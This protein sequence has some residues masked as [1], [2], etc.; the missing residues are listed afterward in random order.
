M[1]LK[2]VLTRAVKILFATAL[3]GLAV[4]FVRESLV[5]VWLRLILS[6]VTGAIVYFI[7]LYFL[8]LLRYTGLKRIG[9]SFGS[10]FNK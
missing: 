2:F 3:M 6:I 10:L 7:L 9:K 8:D 5:N 4:Y 1:R